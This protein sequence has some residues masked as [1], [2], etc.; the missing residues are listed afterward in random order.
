ML[1]KGTQDVRTITGSLTDLAIRKL[2][3]PARGQ[4][5]VWDG[6]VPGFGLRISPGGTRTF[7]LVY[8]ANG[9]ARRLTIGRYPALSLSEARVKAMDALNK[10]AHGTDPRPAKSK[11]GS[12]YRFSDAV[13]TFVRLHCERHNRAITRRD[14]ERILKNRF[15]SRWG[16]R[17]VGEISRADVLK[18]LDG[19]MQEGM[20]S[21]ANHALAA[22]RKFFN[23]CIERGLIDQSPA[24]G[25]KKPAKD[26]SCDR[27]LDASEVKSVWRASGMLAY[28][29]EQIVKLLMLTAQR[30]NE[31]ANMRWAHINLA[32]KCWSLPSAFTKNNRA[33]LVPLTKGAIEILTSMPKLSDDL[34]FPSR[35]LQETCFSDFSRLKSRLDAASEVR[36]WTL[37]DLRR[38]AATH[39]ASMGIGPHVIERILNHATGTLGGVAGIY[40]RFEYLPEMR[41]ALEVWAGFIKKATG[42]K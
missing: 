42:Q 4:A 23:W 39:M 13:D 28:P 7:V 3:P 29:S 33:H 21:A 20:P 25:I 17:G 15:V 37:H 10:V 36:G 16:K 11:E 35:R 2:T 38:T 6:K 31:V 30:R 5:E 9:M 19:I 12:G 34:V 41:S 32:E 40:N 26:K 14:T 22:I 24:S 27:V 1:P 18:V 8:R